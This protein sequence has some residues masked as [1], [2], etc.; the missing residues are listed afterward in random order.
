MQRALVTGGGGFVGLAIVRKL[1]AMGI[2][3]SVAGRNHYPEAERLGARCLR[4]DI[5]NPEFL[6]QAVAGCDTVFHAAAK[7]GI[8]GERQ[9]YYSVNVT[10]TGNVI[11]ACR[12]GGVRRL[13]QT[14]TPSVV[15]NGRDIEG[16]DESLPYSENPLCR[17]A[18]TK[19]MAEKMVL[20]ANSENLKTLAIRP[21]LVWGP[22]DTQIIPRLLQRGRD[23][24][25]RIVGSGRNKVDITYVDNVAH[26]HILAAENLENSA[27]AAGEAFFISQGQPVVLW[28]W[29]ND[30]FARVGLPPVNR[31]ISLPA[32]YRIGWL[33]EKT[34]ALLRRRQEPKMT[35]FLAEQLAMSHWFSINKAQSILAYA[36]L[37]SGGTGMEKLL[38]WLDEGTRGDFGEEKG[39]TAGIPR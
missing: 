16:G 32:A 39:G 23:G 35:R 14:S 30:L 38:Q 36:P 27:S 25:L 37:V 1:V 33:L 21:H 8:W 7:A 19:I 6:R 5:R 22:G 10:G 15:F 3:T 17:Y 26:A 13:V 11:E 9:E 24:D 29:I 2:E 28:E 18:A 34:Y 31:R 4:G 12:Q 20:A